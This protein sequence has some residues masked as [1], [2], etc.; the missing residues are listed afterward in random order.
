MSRRLIA[1]ILPAYWLLAIVM[2]NYL[3]QFPVFFAVGLSWLC[4]VY[5]LVLPLGYVAWLAA[6]AFFAYCIS[7]FWKSLWTGLVVGKLNGRCLGF[8]F[9]G[10][11][12]SLAF[13]YSVSFPWHFW[14]CFDELTSCLLFCLMGYALSLCV[15]AVN[16]RIVG[17]NVCDS[18]RACFVGAERISD[19][20][21]FAK[22]G[23]RFSPCRFLALLLLAFVWLAM[24]HLLPRIFSVPTPQDAEEGYRRVLPEPAGKA[25]QSLEISGKRV[26]VK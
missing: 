3:E 15:C 13:E 20:A 12:V 25:W 14:G 9:L 22:G 24:S 4:I 21:R 11:A 7:R 6:A 5:W 26:E 23:V 16:R 19:T 1:L 8:Y 18:V 2:L 10:V 17:G